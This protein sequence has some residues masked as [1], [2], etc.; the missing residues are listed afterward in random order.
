M[1]Y[2]FR[3]VD[4]G[5]IG[6]LKLFAI[7]AVIVALTVTLFLFVERRAL[8]RELVN[9]SEILH[10]VAS[11]RAD[12]HD[13]HLTALSAVASG[14]SELRTDLFL[15][16]A[17]T[18]KQFYPTVGSIHLIILGD[19]TVAA[20]TDALNSEQ[21]VR[22]II[23]AARDSDGSLQLRPLTG[24]KEKYLLVK[25]SPNT[26]QARYALAL[27]IDA[28]ALI[29]SDTDF[30]TQIQPQLRLIAPDGTVLAGP[31]SVEGIHFSKQLGSNSQPLL[32]ET[33]LAPTWQQLFPIRPILITVIIISLAYFAL[34]LLLR[35]FARTRA[36]E[37]AAMIGKQETRLAH[38]SRVNALGEMASG[39]AHELTQPLTAILSQLQAGKHL[40]KRGDENA[41]N[42]VLNSSIEQSKRASAI[43]ERMR[44]W[45]VPHTSSKHDTKI[46]DAISTVESLLAPEAERQKIRLGFDLP[47]E[48]LIVKADPVEL[49][50]V[51]FNLVRN[52][53]DAVATVSV[54]QVNVLLMTDQNNAIIEVSDNG[55]GVD[56][57]IRQRLF[58]PFV[59]KKENGT[60]LGLALSHRLVEEMSGNIALSNNTDRT[61]FRVQLPLHEQAKTRAKQ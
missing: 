19:G 57:T 9:Q 48:P 59:S 54:P 50:Q 7:W 36:A 38:A 12:Q 26:D 29:Q 25:R 52:A 5:N 28:S 42:D 43:L 30:W 18:I 47:R 34:L 44:K 22:L 13:A 33:T 16:V 23:N 37:R 27:K 32:L 51:V 56:E 1:S 58:E 6:K 10:R 15:Q 41:L 61:I 31:N 35:Q 24:E 45:S 3:N 2:F 46:Q 11:Q 4:Q 20:Q 21:D 40:L 49:E 39:I 60:G 14:E 17:M 55:P 53:L 8:N